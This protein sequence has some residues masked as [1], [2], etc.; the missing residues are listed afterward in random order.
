MFEREQGPRW[1]G[2]KAAVGVG[3]RVHLSAWAW[4]WARARSQ[5]DR[6]QGGCERGHSRPPVGLGVAFFHFIVYVILPIVFR[7]IQE[8]SFTRPS[9]LERMK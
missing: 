2:L 6:A 5:V 7:K 1:I 8:H 9:T 3:T 4:A